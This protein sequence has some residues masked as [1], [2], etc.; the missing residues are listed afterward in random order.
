[1][2]IDSLFELDPETKEV[3]GLKHSFNPTPRNLRRPNALQHAISM[4]QML[5][6]A[7]TLDGPS[8]TLYAMLNLE[9]HRCFG[10]GLK[11]H[12]IPLMGQAFLRALKEVL[13]CK[14]WSLE[15]IMAWEEVLDLINGRVVKGMM[16]RN[17]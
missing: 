12:H 3:F 8:N 10:I 17:S 4:I 6:A 5:N 1:M 11:P 13:G 16:A 7:L 14:Q 9:G 15:L 2:F